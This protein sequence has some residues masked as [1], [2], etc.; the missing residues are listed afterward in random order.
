MLNGTAEVSTA[1][2]AL[3]Q[4]LDSSQIFMNMKPMGMSE[5]VF[6]IFKNSTSIN[7]IM[8]AFEELQYNNHKMGSFFTENSRNN[9]LH[10]LDSFSLSQDIKNCILSGEL[11]T[12]EL[13]SVINSKLNSVPEESVHNLYKSEE[14][15]IL[16]KEEML[17]HWTLRPSELKKEDEVEQY[18]HKLTTDLNHM[19]DVIENTQMK[20]SVVSN[21][22]NHLNENINFMK[23]LNDLFSYM[24]LPL[25]LQSQNAHSELYVY[26]KVKNKTVNEGISILLHLDMENLGP[27][28]IYVDLH[29]KSLL[30][31]FYMN[32][33]MIPFITEHLSVLKD[34]LSN[35][36][37]IVTTEVT[38]R[39]KEINIVD[40]FMKQEDSSSMVKRYNFDIRT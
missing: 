21:Q 14:F 36:G 18:F 11:N 32:E 26:S 25:K 9:L 24:Q 1:A 37:Y 30:S 34:A 20:N 13:L 12:H 7:T 10:L 38:K 2:Q 17:N 6:N 8:T 15:K 40:G 27:L 3:K 23:T 29:N 19:K 28:D 39:T 22:V 16:L 33:N 4:F 35:M 5:E 31:K